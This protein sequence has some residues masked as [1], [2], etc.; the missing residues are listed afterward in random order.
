MQH[1]QVKSGMCVHGRQRGGIFL[2]DED[3]TAENTDDFAG[4]LGRLWLAPFTNFG[5]AETIE[6]VNGAIDDFGSTDN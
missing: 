5:V 1:L 2:V 6:G 4:I 3:A